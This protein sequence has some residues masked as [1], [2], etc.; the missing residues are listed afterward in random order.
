MNRNYAERLDI[1]IGPENRISPGPPDQGQPTHFLPR[2]Q[3][4][5][6]TVQVPAD[7]GD[8]TLTWTLTVH[9]ETVAVPGHLRPEWQIDALRQVT[10]GNTPPVLRLAPNGPEAQGPRGVRA[11]LDVPRSNPVTLA[12]WVTDDMALRSTGN[13]PISRDPRLGVVW[14]K[15]RGPGAVTFSEAEPALDPDGKA[16][17]TATF[18][19]PGE[20]VLRVL[21]WDDSGP[22]LATMAVGFQCCWTNGYV[23]VSVD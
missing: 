12:A 4:G 15:F 14:T 19:T 3:T 9:G 10:T 6:F 23:A 7:F 8:R 22:Q 5:L 13:Y 21:A 18:D 20:Y 17:T 1:P 11:A 16:V 2:R